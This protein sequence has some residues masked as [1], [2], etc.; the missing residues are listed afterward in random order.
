MKP[1]D[2]QAV[3]DAL[4]FY[5]RTLGTILNGQSMVV[6]DGTPDVGK[7]L[8]IMQ[9]EV[10]APQADPMGDYADKHHPSYVEKFGEP[11]APTRSTY[12][13]G[14]M[15]TKH[16][17]TCKQ[18]GH[19]YLECPSLNF[20]DLFAASMGLPKLDTG[21]SAQQLQDQVKAELLAL[22]PEPKEQ[23]K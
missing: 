3:L 11:D 7:A 21:E 2:A 16:C 9:A 14:G 13:G 15:I 17:I 23:T 20:F 12:T 22:N 10:D 19:T 6:P 1:Q 5:Q 4:N 8:A 18:D